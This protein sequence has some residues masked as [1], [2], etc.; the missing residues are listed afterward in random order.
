MF[1]YELSGCGFESSCSHLSFRFRT[2]FKQGVPWHSGNYRL[3][4]H[5]DM[6]MSHDK[7]IVIVLK[8]LKQSLFFSINLVTWR[9]SKTSLSFNFST[10]PCILYIAQRSGWRLQPILRQFA[11][12]INHNTDTVQ[13]YS[14]WNT[15]NHVLS[16]KKEQKTDQY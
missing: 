7:N 1:I 12:L 4:I 15:S 3:R 6:R 16:E 2:C 8:F 13:Q 11:N 14:R 5:S 9:K 10:N